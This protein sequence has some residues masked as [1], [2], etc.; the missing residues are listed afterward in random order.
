[1]MYDEVGV[2]SVSTSEMLY[3]NMKVKVRLIRAGPIL[4]KISDNTNVGQGI[5]KSS[6]YTRPIA[7]KDD[8]QK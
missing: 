8:Y 1:M 2:D 6:L 5:G 3:P 4:Y 7:L